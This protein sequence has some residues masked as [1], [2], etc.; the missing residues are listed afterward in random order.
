MAFKTYTG[1]QAATSVE[2]TADIRLSN[3]A[4]TA[5]AADATATLL[6]GGV[7]VMWL[8]AKAG[9]SA[10]QT[11]KGTLPHDAFIIPAPV[12]ITITGAGATVR[13]DT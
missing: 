10:V 13:L 4:L 9:T 5:A 6:S 1:A 2:V 8:A 3:F 11:S 7:A 12:T